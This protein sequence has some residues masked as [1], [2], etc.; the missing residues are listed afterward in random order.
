MG[1]MGSPLSEQPRHFCTEDARAVS[2]SSGLE[3]CSG[4]RRW[5]IAVKTHFLSRPV[6]T[7]H[8][9]LG[10]TQT[11]RPLSEPSAFYSGNFP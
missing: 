10:P 9:T 1:I 8:G 2:V 5:K 11:S 4:L 3:N 7:W 6:K